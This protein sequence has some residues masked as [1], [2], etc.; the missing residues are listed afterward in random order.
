MAQAPCDTALKAQAD[1]GP[2]GYR[3]RGT[4]CEG[5]FGRLVSSGALAIVSFTES[6]ADY[7]P[8]SST[9]LML[10]WEAPGAGQVRAPVRVRA[11]P[12][13]Q[14]L[15]YQMDAVAGTGTKF[16]W[17]VD[18]LRALD[19]HRRDIGITA[20]ISSAVGDVN[21]DV[22][23][24]VRVRQGAA[25]PEADNY[26]VAI[27]PA[28]ELTEVYVTLSVVPARGGNKQVVR[29][30][31]A[32]DYGYYPADRRI[33]FPLDK[34]DAAGIYVLEVGAS[35]IAGGSATASFYFFHPGQRK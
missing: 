9:P 35:L 33:D 18:V 16:T 12:L 7:D 22:H 28:T 21:R 23:L 19:I 5:S 25:G 3:M 11:W 14:K 4:R 24:P 20:W 6:F 10:E 17:P 26:E 2:F 32:L 27:Y 13:R 34:P 31:R 30:A 1:P 15:Y 8:G 29:P